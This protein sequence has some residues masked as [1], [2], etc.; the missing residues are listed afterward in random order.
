[1]TELPTGI[2]MIEERDVMVAMR[3]GV[4]LAVDVYRPRAQGKFP[5][6]YACAL[7]NKDMQGPDM[8]DVLPP[9]PA[10]SPLWFGPI[11]AG[12]TRRFLAAGYIHVIAQSR[13]TAKSE[14]QFLDEQWD[15]YD[16]IEWISKQVWCDGNI[17]MV[18]ISAYAGEQWRA[19]AQQ[20]PAL[21]AIFPY[22]AC[23]AYG[24][25]FGFRDFYPGG[26]LHAF[27]YLLD[28]FSTVHELRG[29]PGEL[30]PEQEGLWKRAM[31]NPDYKMYANLYNVLTQKGQRTGL[32]YGALV[33]PWEEAGTVERS[34]ETFNE[35][36]V[37]FYTGSGAYA[38]TYK[39]H[40]LGAQH[41]FQNIKQPRKLLFTGPAHLERPFN[42]FHDDIIRW[43]DHWLKGKDNGIMDEPPVRYWV[44]G[45]NE[46][47]TGADWP[48]PETRWTKYYL[49]SWER[50]TTEAPRPNS[51]TNAAAPQPDVFSQ[52]PP[53]QTMKVERLRYMTDPLPHDLLVAGPISLTFYASIDQSDTNW[54]IVL[55]D[56]GPDVS[57]R[58]AREGERFVPS[59]L[60]EREL[61]RGWLKASYRA[62]DPVRSKPW[63][64]F[65]KLT[66]ELIEPV[67]PGAIV[68]YQVHILATANEF[69]AGHRICLDISSM[70]IPTGTGAMTNVEYQPYHVASSRAVTYKIYRDGTY[71]SHLLLPVIPKS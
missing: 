33:Q 10:Y 27:P 62:L 45:A 3:D 25:M 20:H 41:Y 24:G 34:E 1:M 43:Y 40:W 9:Q 47:R 21:K 23:G 37:P 49:S 26:L 66:R 44:M 55:K 7:H 28:V 30:P 61:T 36:K 6:L 2:D 54:I 35:I 59:D 4:R 39:L 52:M 8:S 56:V 29:I 60:P 11:E 68:E 57:V 70:D 5:V 31:Q 18:G 38:Y 48:L 58:T 22:D 51:E 69:K 50:L 13:G 32:M 17:G 42:A 15:H 71:P 14:G 63:E 64:P 65:H 16:L 67:Q 53:T 19:A 46:W 12:D